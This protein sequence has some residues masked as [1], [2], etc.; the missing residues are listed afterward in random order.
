MRLGS[1]AHGEEQ[2]RAVCFRSTS[3]GSISAQFDADN[4]FGQPLPG[5]ATHL[6]CMQF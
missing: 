1:L 3:A 5:S 6:A 4:P 2:S